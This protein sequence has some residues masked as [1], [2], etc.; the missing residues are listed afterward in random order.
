MT[1][2]NSMLSGLEM[3]KQMLSS[4]PM[5]LWMKALMLIMHDLDENSNCHG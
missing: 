2:L 4:S 5:M 3:L 1:E